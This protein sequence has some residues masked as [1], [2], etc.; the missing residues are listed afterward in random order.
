MKTPT[1]VLLVVIAAL[2][3]VNLIANLPPQEAKAQPH[4]RAAPHVIQFE[5]DPGHSPG[6]WARVYRLWS[7]GVIEEAL[8]EFFTDPGSDPD[9]VPDSPGRAWQEIPESVSLPP[10]VRI[11]RIYAGVHVGSGAT[12]MRLRSDGVVERNWHSAANPSDW[13]GWRTPPE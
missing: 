9:C 1:T 12:L 11:T 6:P 3:A 5:P 2:L 10:G 8:F 13:C 7:D 4:L